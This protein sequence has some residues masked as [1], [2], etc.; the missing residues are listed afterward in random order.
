MLY[1]YTKVLSMESWE[2]NITKIYLLNILI[3]GVSQN[4]LSILLDT[5]M[6]RGE[7]GIIAFAFYFFSNTITSKLQ[8]CELIFKR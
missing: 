3:F 1:T 8:I 4:L 2:Y 6:R 7:E 5:F